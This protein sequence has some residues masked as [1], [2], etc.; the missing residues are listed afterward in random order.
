M[1]RLSLIV[2]V[3]LAPLVAGAGQ[4]RHPE[5]PP[6]PPAPRDPSNPPTPARRNLG[7]ELF[8]DNRLSG[9]GFTACNNCHVYNTHWQDNLVK[10][11]PD[12]S[13]GTNFFT[14]PFNT[15]SLINIVYRP[16]F[17]RDGRLTDLGHAFT[18]PWIEDNQ[19]LGKTRPAAATALAG[20]LRAHSG[21]VARFQRA[22]RKDIRTI[23]DE[24]V[25][26]LAGKAL[27]VFA[28][29]IVTRKS[30][31]DRWN[32]GKGKIPEAAEQGV[33][34]FTGKVGC[35]RCHVGPNFS[36]GHFH[37]V[38]TSLPGPGG[39]RPDEGRAR[40]TGDPADGGK[41]LTPTL[42]QIGMT[43]PYFHDGS[44]LTLAA[45]IDHLDAHSGDD[46]N[47]DPLVGTPLGLT[48]AE[49]FQIYS[50]LRTLRS[51][52]VVVRGPTGKL[53]DDAAVARLRAQLPR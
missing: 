15:E 11:R 22:F 53:C 29:Q 49:K 3:L 27:A 45:V 28:R 34:L 17:F 39:V 23:E 25:F 6:L 37:N 18:E 50:F 16:F 7:A 43:S 14:L 24:E 10:P 32:E 33:A 1:A 36:D 8:F 52:P 51:P 9:S 41:F 19:Q 48:A 35:V 42:R 21:Y 12:A 38:S 13:Q 40:V 46:P 5:F 31:F 44:G 2:L 4:L 26:D 20:M 47:H 30:P